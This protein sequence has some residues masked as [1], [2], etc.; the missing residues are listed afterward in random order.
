MGTTSGVEH[1]AGVL[2]RRVDSM[3]KALRRATV[4]LCATVLRG[5]LLYPWESHNGAGGGAM[6]APRWPW[7]VERRKWKGSLLRDFGLMT[8]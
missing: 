4:S 7:V 5:K 2:G 6:M 1:A 3:C 8:T